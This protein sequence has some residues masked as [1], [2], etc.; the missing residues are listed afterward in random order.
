MKRAI[1]VNKY[2]DAYVMVSRPFK[3]ELD[4]LYGSF[5]TAFLN[6]FPDYIDEFNSLL[7]PEERIDLPKGK[8]NTSLRIYALIRLGITDLTQIADF[9]HY[10]VQTVYNYKSKIKKAS[11]VS[12]EEFEE[13]VKSIGRMISKYS[14]VDPRT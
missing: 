11:R 6:L 14:Q 12:P 13:K 7:K 1:K 3:N 9:L 4:G 5:D 10:S 2:D 8:L